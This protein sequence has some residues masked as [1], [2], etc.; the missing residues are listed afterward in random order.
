[1]LN[2]SGVWFGSEEIYSVLEQSEFAARIDDAICVGQR[3]PQDEDERVLLFIK[4]RPDQKLDQSFEQ[5]IRTAIRAVLSARHV[6]AHILEVKE[7]P[8]SYD[9]FLLLFARMRAYVE[10]EWA[11]KLMVHSCSTRSTVRKLRSL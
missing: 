9:I 8:V 6:P 3:R 1:V 4:M 5:A 2:P 7:I 11:P 10:K